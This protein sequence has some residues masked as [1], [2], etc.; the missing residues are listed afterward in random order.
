MTTGAGTT[1]RRRWIWMTAACL[2]IAALTWWLGLSLSHV[3]LL[4]LSLALIFVC[5]QAAGLP[6]SSHFPR[7]PYNRRDGTRRDVSSLSWSLYGNDRAL[8]DP[9]VRRLWT[10]GQRAC[11][12]AGID[13]GS[14]AGRGRAEELLG[15]SALAFLDDPDATAVDARGMS[16]Y[17]TAFERLDLRKGSR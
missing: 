2:A 10:V 8:N 15:P 1:G 6:S 12:H 9:A 3:A 14:A 4:V 16:E 7:L 11:H 13:F 5:T 17:L